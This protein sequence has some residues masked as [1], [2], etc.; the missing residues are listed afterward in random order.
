[1]DFRL[2]DG[3]DLPR[4]SPDESLKGIAVEPL[5]LHD[6]TALSESLL[7][8][9][10]ELSWR[11]EGV[12]QFASNRVPFIINNDGRCSEAAARLLFANLQD[13]APGETF[14]VLEMGAGCGLFAR[15]FIKAFAALCEAEQR[16]WSDRLVYIVTDGSRR[17]VEHWHELGVFR[18]FGPRVHTGTC[19]AMHPDSAADLDGAPLLGNALRC[20]IANY[21]LDV[22]PSSVCRRKGSQLEELVIRVNLGKAQE[23]PRP[24]AGLE[25]DQV[26]ALVRSDDSEL[27][28]SLLPLLPLL[29]VEAAFRPISNE[30]LAEMEYALSGP[31]GESMTVNHGAFT[32]IERWLELL[33]P[34]GFFLLNDYG[35]VARDNA[36]A[37]AIP[38]QF[39]DTLACG[40][41]FPLLHECFVRTGIEVAAPAG[42]ADR[43]IHSRILFKGRLKNTAEAFSTL[44]SRAA[45]LWFE[46]KSLEAMRLV[47][48]GRRSEALD[49]FRDAL[50]RAPRDWQL[51]GRA[52][53]FVGLTLQEHKAGLEL[54]RSALELNPW[55][56]SWLWNVLGDCLFALGHNELAHQAYQ[57][58]VNVDPKDVRAHFNLSFTHVE[59]GDPEQALLAIA[60]ALAA[61]ATGQYRERLVAKQAQIIDAISAKALGDQQRLAIR[62]A[63]LQAAASADAVGTNR[64]EGHDG[65]TKDADRRPD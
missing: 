55:F 14:E 40:I 32:A 53:E 15:Y 6:F 36:A 50:S 10:S 25:I 1:M 22:L 33:A 41:N 26:R 5:M 24:H 52:A 21:S 19:N 60:R 30:R 4:R 61:D 62:H 39:G 28:T 54:A 46:E 23:L 44:F 57:E 16:D 48:A 56:S 17:T 12:R 64:G 63:T 47:A 34:A 9:L 58:A 11:S 8:R 31:D 45:D 13:A 29:E 7:W 35:F 2:L 65:E 42:D 59:R 51:I 18:E 38:Q 3:L 49:A 37:P 43:A 20:V 27:Q